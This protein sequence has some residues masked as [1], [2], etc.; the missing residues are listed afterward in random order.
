MTPGKPKLRQ[1]ADGYY[2]VLVDGEV[3]GAVFRLTQRYNIAPRPLT[4]TYWR[5][6]PRSGGD[7]TTYSTRRD[8]LA[9][10]VGP[11]KGATP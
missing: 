11:T 7:Q 9:A 2:D 10:L 4:V 8:A 1:V 3:V 5:A 6:S